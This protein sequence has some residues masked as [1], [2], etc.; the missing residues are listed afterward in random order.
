MKKHRGMRSLDIVVLLKIAVQHQQKWLIKNLANELSISQ[1]EVSESLNRP[2]IASLLASDKKRLMKNNLLDFLVHGLRYVFPVEPGMVQRGIVTAHSAYPL[3]DKISSED[4]YI[5]PWARSNAR[6][7]SIEPL[8]PNVPDACIRD[9]ELHAL[10]A[11][12]DAI[13]IGRIREK[14]I[15]IDELRRLLKE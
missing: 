13:R 8:H 6:G 2:R 9:P 15:A 14:K 11:L 5:W 12:T 4:V 3:H 7:H 10:L 1:S